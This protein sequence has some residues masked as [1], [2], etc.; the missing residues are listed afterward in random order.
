MNLSIKLSIITFILSEILFFSA[1]FYIFCS[2]KSFN[3]F[4]FKKFYLL[5]FKLNFLISIINLIILVSSRLTFII[6]IKINKKNIFNN[7]F[8]FYTI[9]LRIYFISIQLIEYKFINF[10]C[11]NSIYFSIFFTLTLFHII[12]VNLGTIIIINNLIIKIT[13]INNLFI[14]IIFTC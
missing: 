1:F 10:N 2:Q 12:H 5:I 13:F 4:F 14:K 7:K 9:F 11:T 3:L 8:L 6:F